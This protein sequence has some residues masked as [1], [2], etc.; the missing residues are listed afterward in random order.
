MWTKFKSYGPFLREYLFIFNKKVQRFTDDS[1]LT[2]VWK[3]KWECNLHVIPKYCKNFLC[4]S[5]KKREKE[6][7]F[8]NSYKKKMFKSSLSIFYGIVT[9]RNNCAFLQMLW[10]LCDT[11][12][13]KLKTRSQC[14][15]VLYLIQCWRVL[16]LIQ[17]WRIPCIFCCGDFKLSKCVMC[18]L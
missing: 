4:E 8:I 9:N 13:T 3:R 1:Y 6:K 17:W 16:Y 10:V 2:C 12:R 7:V 15:R 5:L 14:W 11:I 18:T